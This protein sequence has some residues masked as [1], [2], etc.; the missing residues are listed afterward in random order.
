M[1]VAIDGWIGYMNESQK[2]TSCLI[3]LLVT[4]W[5]ITDWSIGCVNELQKKKRDKA[6]TLSIFDGSDSCF[7]HNGTS[8][9]FCL[10]LYQMK[11]CDYCIKWSTFC[12]WTLHTKH[13]FDGHIFQLLWCKLIIF[14]SIVNFDICVGDASIQSEKLKLLNASLLTL[15]SHFY[16]IFFFLQQ[17]RRG[18]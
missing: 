7:K 14:G 2:E 10:C 16:L 15:K 17:C 8:F 6:L 5:L 18:I 3:L 12:S 1:R 11:A 4:S 9:L 13:S